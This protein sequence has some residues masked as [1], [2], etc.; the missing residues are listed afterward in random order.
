[1]KIDRIIAYWIIL[2]SEHNY[3]TNNFYHFQWHF[4][5]LKIMLETFTWLA[6]H[7]PQIFCKIFN[8]ILASQGSLHDLCFFLV[9]WGGA[10]WLREQTD[11]R[12]SVRSL[13]GSRDGRHHAPQGGVQGCARGRRPGSKV[14]QLIMTRT[15]SFCFCVTRLWGI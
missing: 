7:L 10:P 11:G 1:M 9:A 8:D 12:G 6:E 14:G 5:W 15:R 3:I 4:I 13:G 2:L